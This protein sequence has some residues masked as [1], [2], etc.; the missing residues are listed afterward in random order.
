MSPVGW[1]PRADRFVFFTQS[2]SRDTA[3]PLGI[4]IREPDGKVT[5]YR[6]LAAEVGAARLSSDGTRI[7]YVVAAT[8]ERELLLDTFPVASSHPQRISYGDVDRPRWSVDGRE[9][10]FTDRGR[11]MAAP[12]TASPVPSA[13]PP[14]KLFDLPSGSYAVD[15]KSARFLVMVPM[16]DATPSVKVTLN[17]RGR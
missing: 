12:V 11:L 6:V 8:G 7:A 3:M 2:T 16:S 1:L 9:L 5:A 4:L 15:P 14:V 10:F 13:G 17:W